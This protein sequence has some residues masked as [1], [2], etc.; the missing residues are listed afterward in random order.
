MGLEEWGGV[1]MDIAGA[2]Q[3]R[4]REQAQHHVATLA[5]LREQG[6]EDETEAYDKATARQRAYD[7]WADG[8]PKGSGVTKRV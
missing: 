2:R 1:V 6:R 3:E 4:E 7:D 5:E 8:V